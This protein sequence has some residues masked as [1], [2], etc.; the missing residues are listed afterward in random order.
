MS[1]ISISSARIANRRMDRPILPNPLIAILTA[2]IPTVLTEQHDATA[3][4]PVAA[5]GPARTKGNR[6]PRGLERRPS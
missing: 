2:T 1:A 4:K 6:A 5:P 3:V